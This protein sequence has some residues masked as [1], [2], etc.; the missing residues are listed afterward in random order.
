MHIFKIGI[1]WYVLSCDQVFSCNT[2]YRASSVIQFSATASFA[3]VVLNFI[4]QMPNS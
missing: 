1:L 3:M 2:A 4:M